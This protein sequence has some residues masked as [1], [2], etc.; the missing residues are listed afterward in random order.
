M[1]SFNKSIVNKIVAILIICVFVLAACSSV[2]PPK[3][4][5]VTYYQHSGSQGIT[6]EKL[7][8]KPIFFTKTLKLKETLS[9]FLPYSVYQTVL[10]T[11]ANTQLPAPSGEANTGVFFNSGPFGNPPRAYIYGVEVQVFLF[12][13]QSDAQNF[14]NVLS[15]QNLSKCSEALVVE[16]RKYVANALFS[17]SSVNLVSVP[18]QGMGGFF[19]NV[20]GTEVDPSPLFGKTNMIF[21]YDC[22]WLKNHV[23]VIWGGTEGLPVNKVN[24]VAVTNELS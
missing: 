4:K 12:S 23:F 13:R 21:G 17:P 2:N 10:T 9:D 1:N 18:S 5:I 20:Q 11:C 6:A 24:L 19:F 3:G 22:F 15:S 8:P 14:Y 16:F 7:L